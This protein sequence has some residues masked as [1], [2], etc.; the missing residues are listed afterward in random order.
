[1]PGGQGCQRVDD[2]KPSGTLG[3]TIQ[4]LLLLLGSS[5]KEL[6]SVSWQFPPIVPNSVPSAQLPQS[7]L[8]GLA[9][10]HRIAPCYLC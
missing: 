9:Y 4:Q 8:S 2:I 7:V 3:G 5:M 1:M 6:K 10:I